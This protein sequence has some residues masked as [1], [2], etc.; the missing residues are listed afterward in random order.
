MNTRFGTTVRVAST[1]RYRITLNFTVF[2]TAFTNYFA[3]RIGRCPTI[4]FYTRRLFFW[5]RVSATD[6]TSVSTNA[7]TSTTIRV[8]LASVR[9]SEFNSSKTRVFTDNVVRSVYLNES[10]VAVH[11][12]DANAIHTRYRTSARLSRDYQFG[13]LNTA[14][15][16]VHTYTHL[17][18]S[19]RNKTLSVGER[20]GY[21]RK[22]SSRDC[23]RRTVFRSVRSE[24][25]RFV[26]A[27]FVRVIII[28]HAGL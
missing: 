17:F 25:V 21:F 28:T 20:S 10:I 19:R 18:S 6:Q 7:R 13:A 22:T 9:R 4:L 3:H 26:Y 5:T 16:C 1:L 14:R 24:Y 8:R 27:Y 11:T 23:S 12:G 2:R 15:S